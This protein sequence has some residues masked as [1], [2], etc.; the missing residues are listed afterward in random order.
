M[1]KQSR[2]RIQETSSTWRQLACCS[3]LV[4]GLAGCGSNA[5]STVYGTVTLDGEP[6]DHGSV[7][8]VPNTN[9]GRAASGSIDTGGNY[10][11]QAGQTGGLPA[12]EY[13]VKVSSR[14]PAKPNPQGGPPTPGKLLTPKRYFNSNRSGLNFQVEAGSNEINL[15][16][17]SD[18]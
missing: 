7:T 5:E 1:R 8:F 4:V 10:K 9:E 14:E 18:E 3:F 17:T 13:V 11:V 2:F 16:L 15:E 12:G 6:L